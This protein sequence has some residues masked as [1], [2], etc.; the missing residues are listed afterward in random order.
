MLQ[1][2][3]KPQWFHPDYFNETYQKKREETKKVNQ[4]KYRWKVITRTNPTRKN[5]LEIFP[6]FTSFNPNILANWQ[7]IFLTLKK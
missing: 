5:V 7:G 2:Q 6:E 3:T 1:I 4:F